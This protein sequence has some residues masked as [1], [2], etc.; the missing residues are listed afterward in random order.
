MAA[1]YFQAGAFK[2]PGDS[3]PDANRSDINL[4][5]AIAF[6]SGFIRAWLRA[7]MKILRLRDLPRGTRTHTHARVTRPIKGGRANNCDVIYG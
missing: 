6:T 3:M 4:Y 2:P 1:G 7:S 5:R